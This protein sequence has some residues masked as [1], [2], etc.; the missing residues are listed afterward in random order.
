MNTNEIIKE[1]FGI[2]AAAVAQSRALVSV[3]DGLKPSMR[4][5]L[6]ANYTDNFVAP[7]KTA[8]YIKLIGSASRFCYHGDASTFGMLI[9]SA[10]PFAMRYPLY[11]T[12]GSYGTLIDSDTHAAPR[13][14][15]GRISPLGSK[16]FSFIKKG[17]IDEWED[18]YDDTEQSPTLLPSIGYWNLCN[19]TSGIGV[20]VA[21]SIPP[22][23]LKEMNMALVNMLDK[24]EWNC[25]MPDFPTGGILLNGKEVKESLENGTGKACLLRAKM[26]YDEQTHTFIVYEIPYATYTNTIC[27]ELHF[28]MEN[29]IVVDS[30][31][32]LTGSEPNI[33][34]KIKKDVSKE[35]AER[36]LY[37]KTSLQNHYSI[38]M[39]MLENSR[40]PKV[41]S[42]KEAMQAYLEFQ[43]KIYK[44]SYEYDKRQVE[45][46]I[47]I[48]E[49][50]LIVL[51]DIDNVIELIRNSD[52]PTQASQRLKE[53]YI[54][55]DL[56]VKEIMKITLSKITKLNKDSFKK[57]KEDLIE[58]LEKI[59]S[60]LSDSKKLEGIIKVDLNNTIKNFADSRRTTIIDATEDE[61]SLLKM[62]SFTSDGKATTS[63][64]KLAKWFIPSGQ[65]YVG[66]SYKGIIYKKNEIPARKKKIFNLDKDDYIIAVFPYIENDYLCFIDKEKHYRAKQMNTLNETKTKL[67]LTQIDKVIS[68]S[69]K[70]TK[71]NFIKFKK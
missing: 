13:Y 41:F 55:T 57:E 15:E 36:I 25:P 69:I 71:E 52:T 28:L 64:D 32:D 24:K 26:R 59:K 45:E 35:E 58:E 48:I 8:K 39:V 12:Q 37:E 11:E 51:D 5:A 18:N 19:G 30:Y 60:I 54:L 62:I 31:L 14:V 65:E 49:G 3:E 9:R 22:F 29:E 43:K 34:I 10:K 6:Y 17:V 21:S 50:I 44:K 20:G 47:E 61:N 33:E 1:N 2:Y 23:N 68:S 53:K 56:Q 70:L 38:N 4:K 16:M 27:D 67:S 42:L 46:K 63:K 7:K 40:Y 66:I